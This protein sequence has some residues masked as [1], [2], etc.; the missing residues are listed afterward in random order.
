MS[1][2]DTTPEW[3]CIGSMRVKVSI[4][5]PEGLLKVIDQRAR[6]QSA[7]RSD[8]IE[9]AVQA[10][11]GQ[12]TR[13]EQNAHDLEIINRHAAFLNRETSDVLAYQT[14]YNDWQ[15]AEDNRPCLFEAC[16]E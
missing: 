16:D 12:A 8:F 10:F 15:L 2:L 3:K 4:T 6:R 1:A 5:L 14:A 13:A 11:I 7:T 9:T